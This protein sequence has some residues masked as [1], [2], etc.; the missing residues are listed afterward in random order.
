MCDYSLQSVKSRPAQVG[1]KLTTYRF[2]TGSGGFVGSDGDTTTAVCVLPGTELAFEEPVRLAFT[3]INDK[4]DG[5]TARFRQTNLHNP[6][7]HHDALEF[8]DG[9]L[10]TLSQLASG[11]TATVLQLP[12]A[13]K[14]E[15]EAKE[16]QRLEVVG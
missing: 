10:V 4:V 6:Y 9:R 12:A 16:Q 7:S 14:T 11:L 15:E 8:P 3:M 1:E 13:P 5:L 2:G